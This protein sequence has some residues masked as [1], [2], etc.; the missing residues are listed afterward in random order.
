MKP[1]EGTDEEKKQITEIQESDCKLL[2]KIV[3]DKEDN[4]GIKRM[5]E[6]GVVE[7]LLFIYTNRD[8]NSITQTYSSAFLHIT[9]NSNDEIQLLLLEKNP[10][11]GLIRLLEHPDDDIASDAIDSIFNILE[12]G[13][14]TTPD[15]NPHPH[16]DSLQACDGIK[17][18]FALFQK[19]GSKY[20]KDQAALCIGYLFRAQQI[21]DPIM[22]QVIISHLKSLLCDSEELM[23]DYTKEALN[24][25]AQ[26]EANRSEILNEAELLKI[27]NNLQREL[28]GT[29]DEKKGILKFQE[30][31]LLLLSSVLDGREDIQLRS[32]AINAGIIDALLQIFTSRDLD[33][34]TRPYINAFIKLTHPSNFIICQL[35]L[36][37]QPF[38]SLLRLLNHKD[39]NVTNS[40]VVSIDNIVYYT[41]LESEL[42]SQ[43]PFFADLAS[44]GGIEKIFSLFKVTT[45]EYSKKVSAVCL[46]IVF[47]AQEIIDHAMI[48]EVITHLKSIINDPDNDIKKLVKYAL[49]CL[50]QN[51]VNKT[52][53][54]SGGFTIPE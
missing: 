47:R 24:Y 48:K 4:I 15:A 53:I 20:C 30:T 18:I 28:K 42:T 50:V 11:P 51:Q 46:G 44:A 23:K 34:I 9:I 27:A 52:E 22:R 3:E 25:L 6:S 8:L 19:N 38:P 54:E 33:E 39:E 31:D 26:N 35:I 16:Y 40:A 13:S 45:N 1:L 29:E 41:S 17:K 49:K 37:K 2:S 7:S 12:V 14:I 32:D 21:T 43:H 10:Y 36:E 5:I